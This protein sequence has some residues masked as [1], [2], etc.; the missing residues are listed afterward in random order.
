MA[1]VLVI[2]EGEV[3]PGEQPPRLRGPEAS[4]EIR[5]HAGLGSDQ[6]VQRVLGFAPGA[7]GWVGHFG[8]DDVLYVAV[9]TGTLVSRFDQRR[10]DLRPGLAV[11]V[12]PKVPAYV[13]NTGDDDLRVVSVLSPP[14]FE[15]AFTLEARS[16][17]LAVVDEREAAS[18]PAGDDRTF[19]V[20]LDPTRGA[21]NVTQFVGFI[22][23]SKAPPHTHTYE[24]AIYVVDGEGILH[25]GD[26]DE[27]MPAGTS[28]FLPP[29]TPHCL[30]NAG[31]GVLKVLGV[32]SPPGSPAAN[33]PTS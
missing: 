25:A 11:L 17:P 32:F 16:G 4:A 29:G 21:R 10:I 30:E 8:A 26:L 23:R 6:L 20:L 14:P 15:G 5:I 12:G 13:M 2:R 27:P 9:G 22:A 3:V 7:S 24:E 19:K 1:G 31:S 33:R 18:E 28:I